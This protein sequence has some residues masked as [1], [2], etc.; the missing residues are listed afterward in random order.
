LIRS[1]LG[2]AVAYPTAAQWIFLLVIGAVAGAVIGA[3]IG[4]VRRRRRYA[5]IGW[6]AGVALAAVAF[7]A[8]GTATPLVG[9]MIVGGPIGALLGALGARF[10]WKGR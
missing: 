4:G 10:L 3:A 6:L 9:A 5:G 1:A 2:V 7:P 8:L